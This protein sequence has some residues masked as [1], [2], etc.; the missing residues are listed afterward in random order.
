MNPRSHTEHVLTTCCCL[1]PVPLIFTGLLTR[2]QRWDMTMLLWSGPSEVRSKPLERPER[3]I[4]VPCSLRPQLTSDPGRSTNTTWT[5]LYACINKLVYAVTMSL[6]GTTNSASRPSLFGPSLQVPQQTQ[7][8]PGS[9][10]GSS[11]GAGQQ[12]QQQQPQ[13]QQ[14]NNPFNNAQI[15]PQQQS[16]T[17]NMTSQASNPQAGLFSGFGNTLQGQS[18]AGPNLSLTQQDHSQQRSS[19]GS[20]WQPG[21]TMSPRM[22]KQ[23][24]N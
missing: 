13:A 11:F 21:S 2:E 20:V 12:L 22:S 10:F 18:L 8:S 19:L 7:Q 24:S 14:Q 23:D 9:L 16:Q 3:I 15:Q 4:M 1:L 5:R 6:F 17:P